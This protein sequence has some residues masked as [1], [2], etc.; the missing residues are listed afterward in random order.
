MSTR[1][2]SGII[3]PPSSSLEQIA[4]PISKAGERQFCSKS[5]T[6]LFRPR[7]IAVIGASRDRTSIPGYLFA[8][9]R[10]SF[11]GVVYPVNPNAAKVQGIPAFASVL[12]IPDEI[13]LAFIAV[14]ANTA[15]KVAHQCVEKQIPVLVVVAAGF[16]ETGEPG[17]ARQQE[18]LQLAHASGTRI[19]GPNC[20]GVFN[21]DPSVKLNGVFSPVVVTPGNVALGMQSGALGVAMP[22]ALA[23]MG[24]G[25]SCFASIGNKMD[26]GEND[27]L[28]YWRDDPA[29]RAIALYLESFQQPRR[30]LQVGRDVARH[31]PVVVLKGGRTAK[32]VRAASSHTAAQSSP[33]ATVNALL[34]QSGVIQIHTLEEM[35]DVTALLATQPIPQGR[36]VAVISNA[37]GLAVMCADALE[38]EGLNAVEFPMELRHQLQQVLPGKVTI[39]NPLDLVASVDPQVYRQGIQRLLASEVVDAVIAIFLPRRAG[40]APG[41][42]RAIR[43]AALTASGSKPVLAVFSQADPPLHALQNTGCHIPCYRFAESAVRALARAAEYSQWLARPQGCLPQFADLQ[44]DHARQVITSAR[45]RLGDRD[46][47]LA[48]EEV[49]QVLSAFGLPTPTSTVVRSADKA[50]AAARQIGG[51]VVVKVV[52]PTV[53]HKSDVGGVVLDVQGDLAVKDAFLRVT[54]A[55]ADDQGALVQPLVQG[56]QEV[57]IGINRDASFGPLVA[58]GL[59]GVLVDLL[60]SVA[61]RLAPLTDQDADDLIRTVRGG[62][63]LQGYRGQPPADVPAIKD[64]LLRVSTMA[65]ALPEVVEMDLNP[66]KVFAP[67]QGLMV[68]DARIRIG[69]H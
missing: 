44:L 5:L 56:G 50:V 15:I 7:T 65:E 28:E 39:R 40:T 3:S 33:T 46:G 35:I 10:Q 14:S 30:F 53:M 29:T 69:P 54:E 61:L 38:L 48:P 1:R 17:A 6:H 18:L 13:D 36:R 57:L 4:N 66:V 9:L 58:F 67:G 25:V 19:L 60:E 20:F 24:V 32:G 52:S 31:K 21:T 47:W 43:E 22:E 42:A 23:G 51:A 41:V 55:V 37:G 64:A 8:N 59:G 62:K 26:I 27:L 12:E 63:L 2:K 49:Q 11:T 16:A 68:V 34:V 45:Q